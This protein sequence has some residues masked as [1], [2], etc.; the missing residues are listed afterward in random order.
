LA[1]HPFAALAKGK[2]MRFHPEDL[3]VL[4][5]FAAVLLLALDVRFGAVALIAAAVID[6]LVFPLVGWNRDDQPN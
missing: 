2:T 3:L 1:G 4:S 6:M 5:A